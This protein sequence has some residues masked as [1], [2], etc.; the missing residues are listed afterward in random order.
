MSQ[1]VP[2]LQEEQPAVEVAEE[3]IA[4]W[5]AEADTVSFIDLAF[6]CRIVYDLFSCR[7]SMKMRFQRGLR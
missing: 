4:F 2:T 1:H 6:Y 3:A 7:I 5:C